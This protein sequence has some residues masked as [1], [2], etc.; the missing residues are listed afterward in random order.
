MQV[1]FLGA[2]PLMETPQAAWVSMIMDRLHRVEEDNVKL[3][4]EVE[5]LRRDVEALKTH[6][7]EITGIKRGPLFNDE[8]NGRKVVTLQGVV[9]KKQCT[10]LCLSDYWQHGYCRRCRYSTG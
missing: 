1:Q 2:L 9:S 4:E 6:T 10:F 8:V 5:R 7:D 3:R